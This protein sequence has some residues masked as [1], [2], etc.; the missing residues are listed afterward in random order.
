[1]IST[2]HTHSGP[3]LV[4]VRG[5]QVAGS[6]Y[7]WHTIKKAIRRIRK[8]TTSESMDEQGAI[9]VGRQPS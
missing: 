6:E 1:L 9:P 3:G 7:Q 8:S 5:C 2:T 4:P